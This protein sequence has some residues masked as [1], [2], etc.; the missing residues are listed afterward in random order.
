MR[1]TGL[2]SPRSLLTGLRVA[3]FVTVATTAATAT[4][5]IMRP[6]T[7][8]ALATRSQAVVRATVRQHHSAWDS[9]KKRIYT[10]TELTVT[11][12][13]SGVA[14][15]TVVVRTI[16]GEVDGVGMKVSGTPRLVDNQD[17]V[18]FLRTDPSAADG[19]TVVGMSQGLYRVEKDSAGRTIAVPGV[20]GMSFVRRNT[21]GSQVVDHHSDAV[22][23]PLSTLRQR[24][25]A[26]LPTPAPREPAPVQA[27]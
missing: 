17:V 24:V 16:G 25:R 20:E 4:A 11:E 22:R 19:F 23:I 1:R 13:I 9:A 10:F 26:A 5:T 15:E 8:E 14:P 18:L 27:Q 21:S 2:V 3:A 12:V 7:V 6:L